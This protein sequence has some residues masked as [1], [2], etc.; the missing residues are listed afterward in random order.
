[1]GDLV[2]IFWLGFFCGFW[3]CV[4]IHVWYSIGRDFG[5]RLSWSIWKWKMGLRWGALRTL[6]RMN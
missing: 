6:F 1:M 2:L 3:A 4:L 5:W